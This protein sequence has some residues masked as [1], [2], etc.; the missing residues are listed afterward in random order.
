[1]NSNGETAL[2]C[3]Q[4]A[5]KAYASGTFKGPGDPFTCASKP[6]DAF[7][8][9]DFAS[10]RSWDRVIRLLTELP[11]DKEQV[12][13]ATV[14]AEDHAM[15]AHA[16]GKA[17]ETEE[18]VASSIADAPRADSTRS[19]R[20]LCTHAS[21]ARDAGEQ[22]LGE[23]DAT[24]T[25]AA[26]RTT[27][28]RTSAVELGP[29]EDSGE[30]AQVQEK[31]SAEA[32][33]KN[34]FLKEWDTGLVSFSF[35]TQAG[36]TKVMMPTQVEERPPLPPVEKRFLQLAYHELVFAKAENQVVKQIYEQVT[37]TFVAEGTSSQAQQH[38]QCR[39][40]FRRESRK[41]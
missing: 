4:Q 33:Q 13:A 30:Q 3:A 6:H 15:Q 19:M 1:M 11:N 34:L 17:P 20:R 21:R 29:V 8:R 25:S 32:S 22:N 2:Q 24:S 31:E 40:R 35:L 27:R 36:V 16:D 10:S 23:R 7:R 37:P 14:D 39:A 18:H 38:G 41:G 12:T 26:P 28:A 5:M 9:I